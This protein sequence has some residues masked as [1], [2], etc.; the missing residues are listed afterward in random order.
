MIREKI[1]VGLLFLLGCHLGY[2]QTIELTTA[3]TVLTNEIE[4]TT[5]S[6][7][8][9]KTGIATTDGS[10]AAQFSVSLTG[11][12]TY[13]VPFSLPPGIKNMVP[14]IGLSYSS[15]AGN[16]L[17]GW[18]WNIS[19]LSTISRIPS[20]KYHDNHSDPVDFDT[21]D[22]YALDGQRL[23]L[24][25]G[26]YGASN[27][28]Y[29]TES[30]S[31]VKIKA[32]GV[33]TYGSSYG[34]LYFVVYFPDGTSAWYGNQNSSSRLEW[35]LYRKEDTQ[36]NFIT[37]DYVQS[38]GL[39]RIDVI[40]Y[41]SKGSVVP[42]NEIKFLYE[43]RERPEVSYIEGRLFERKYILDKVEVKGNGTLYRSYQITHSASLLGYQKVAS[44]TETNANGV[45]FS[46]LTFSYQETLNE[47]R[48]KTISKSSSMY[49]H[50]KDGI[51][52]GDFNGDGK[53]DAGTFKKDG[54]EFTVYSNL[55]DGSAGGMKTYTSE[56]IKQV[57]ASRILTSQ[58][59][60]QSAQGITTVSDYSTSQTRFKTYDLSGGNTSKY[61]T[62]PTYTTDDCSHGAVVHKPFRYVSGDFNGDGLTDVMALGK[63]YEYRSRHRTWYGSCYSNLHYGYTKNS[64]FF[65]LKPSATNSAPYSGNLLIAIGST[66]KVRTGDFNGDGKTDIFHFKSGKVYI[67][68][69]NTAHQLEHLHTETDASINLD[70]PVLMGDYNGDGKTDFAIPTDDDSYDW[71]FFRSSGTGIISSEERTLINYKNN[72][73][74]SGTFQ[75][76]NIYTGSYVDITNPI[77]QFSYVAQDFNGD[78]KTDILRYHTAT[79]Y[80][81]SDNH[82]KIQLFS[83]MGEFSFA[84]DFY[85]TSE[86]SGVKKNG[87]PLVLEIELRNAIPEFVFLD[88]DRLQFYEFQKSHQKEM[89]LL[90]V[91]NNSVKTHISYEKLGVPELGSS[92]IYSEDANEVYPFV[93]INIAPGLQLVKAVTRTGNAIT[94]TQEYQY[95][96]AVSHMEGLGFLGFQVFKKTNWYGDGVGKLWH[97]SLQNPHLRGAVTSQWLATSASLTP[98]HYLSKT[99][100]TYDFSLKANMSSTAYPYSVRDAHVE[101][102]TLL[103]TSTDDVANRSITLK[104]GFRFTASTSASYSAS[105][106]PAET[107]AVESVGEAGYAGVYVNVPVS[108]LKEDVL[109]GITTTQRFSYDAYHNLLQSSTSFPGGSKVKSYTYSN[110]D[111]ATDQSYHIG[112]PTRIVETNTLGSETFSTTQEMTYHNNLLQTLRKKGHGETDW[113]TE[114]MDYDDFGN[115]ISKTLSASGI[116]SRRESFAYDSSGRFLIESTDIE[117]LKTSYVYHTDFGYPLRTTNP[118]GLTSTY[119][120]DGWGRLLRETDYLGNSTDYSYQITS[121]N[122]QWAL[123]KHIEFADGGQ[124]TE[125]F[126]AFGWR[127]KQKTLG[128]HANPVYKSFEYDAMG[129]KIRESEPYFDSATQWNSFAFDHYGRLAS[130]T[131]YTGK[132]VYTT[133]SGL[134]VTVDDGVKT[135]TSTKDAVGNIV[136]MTD[137]GGTINYTYYAN[138]SMKQADYGSHLVTTEIDGWGRKIQLNDPSAGVYTY[139]Y[140]IL[141]EMLS[142]TTPKGSTAYTYDDH[143]KLTQKTINGDATDL[144]LSYAYDPSSKLLQEISGTDGI[145]QLQYR[146]TYAYDSYQR[147]TEIRE[148]TATANFDKIYAYD[149]LGRV[150]NETYSATHVASGT[151]S[152][153][154]VQNVFDASGLLIGLRDATTN[155]SLWQLDAENAK[156]QATRILLGNGM[157]KTRTYDAYGFLTEVSDSKEG[158]HA[159]AMDYSFDAMQ[160]NLTSRTNHAFANY[161]ENF[162]YD[163]QDRL[164]EITGAT[165]HSQSYDA[166]GRIT[167]NSGVG[168]YNYDNTKSY[169]LAGIDLNAQGDLHYQQHAPQQITYN[170]F[171]KPVHISETG[172][173]RVDFVYGPLQN[174]THAYYGGAQLDKTAR[175]FHKQYASVLPVEMIEDTAV[176][177]V[178]IISYIG[179]DAYTA[180]IAYIKQ[181]GGDAT[182]EFYYLHRDY[183]GSI[184]AISDSAGAVVEQRQFGAW[185]QTDRFVAS[186]GTTTFTHSSLIGRGY[187]GH[188]HF[189][190]VG[191]IHMNGRMYDPKLGRFLSPDNYIQDPFNTQSYNRYGYVWN[192]PLKYVDPSG[193][194]ILTLLGAIAYGAIVG[195]AVS[196]AVYTVSAAITGNW[197]FS[198][199]GQ[200]MLYGAIGGA[201]SGGLSG[202]G[203]LLSSSSSFVQSATFN[204]MSEVASQVGTS[205]AMGDDVTLGTIAGALAG[206]AIGGKMKSWKGVKGGYLKN[207]FGEIGHNTIKGAARGAISG[208]VGAAVDGRNIGKGIANGARNGAI[209]GA[210]QSIAMIAAFGA[211]YKPTDGQLKY[212]NEMAGAREMSTNK[213]AWRKGGLYQG[214]SSLFGPMY[215][216]EVT[217]GNSVATF[218]NTN[219][220]TFG[221]EYGHIIQVREQGWARFQAR[222]FYEQIINTF[223]LYIDP[224]SAKGYNEYEANQMLYNVKYN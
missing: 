12:A 21:A 110:N 160:G 67:Y 7:V 127:V 120:Y 105:I 34:P 147:P 150:A 75:S 137:P 124:A 15:Q 60:L 35:A 95:G 133:Y 193:E 115:I 96:G 168:G 217:W 64:Y 153:V 111:S 38:D 195:A 37:Y 85:I 122:G 101:R 55:R 44:I 106:V 141:G 5:S 131:L 218:N 114:T 1:R 72:Y 89:T 23:I 84:Q 42:P 212:A 10:T 13:A 219:S 48:Q 73:N 69:L 11:A 125:Y 188:E 126:N 178:K 221:H 77:Y 215:K 172:G 53:T 213:V 190:E 164:L 83:N 129:R 36:G 175:R 98:E 186:D 214:I 22:R 90:E 97:V 151:N 45:S 29:Q 216:R 14:N 136:R 79:S 71:K 19:G 182:D 91:Q 198:G 65:E 46:P 2:S 134:S 138:G 117:G 118:Y 185:G 183:L 76:G 142:E 40:K 187:T 30:Y 116:A 132:V 152:T 174:R 88:K 184:L 201:I 47:V 17:A 220:D 103:S 205:L 166:Q 130:Q 156:G 162:S 171:K 194:F 157:N 104:P 3:N 94:Q 61:I 41:G 140:S 163:T 181:S 78:G 179:G 18:G 159:L 80:S 31:N 167:E 146:Y 144:R 52:A 128:L 92:S 93:N 102:N 224:Y 66:D 6:T 197:S 119:M 81:D 180:P 145:E 139:Q 207:A 58:Q 62:L 57:F 63:S 170:A 208:G 148:E 210:S 4:E 32:H 49:D 196:A 211:T 27:S 135:M 26:E 86:N 204:M 169:Q 20:T 51:F 199:L 100:Y 223:S 108:I 24:T 123:S 113:L 206:G 203:S 99:D 191:L 200:A 50:T 165:Q 82:E 155:A 173:G 176:G 54:K 8:E 74:A 189:F 56:T 9:A 192:N 222:G 154:S 87:V 16:G 59:K 109:K 158:V 43:T 143:G 33:S 209:G 39:L 107:Q 70:Y 25:S 28:E 149:D 202:V 121:V 68:G 177:S 112:R 161:T